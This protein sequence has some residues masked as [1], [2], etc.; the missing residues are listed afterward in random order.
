VLV[1]FDGG[2]QAK[3]FSNFVSDHT[4]AKIRSRVQFSELF[5]IMTYL[6]LLMESD[7]F[8]VFQETEDEIIVELEGFHPKG[9]D[10]VGFNPDG[11]LVEIPKKILERCTPVPSFSPWDQKE[12]ARCL[13][14][15]SRLPFEKIYLGEGKV[16]SFLDRTKSRL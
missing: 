1:I 13:A 11:G 12:Y 6:G 3:A 9:N 14:S 5:A 7:P 10:V 16:A 15:F 2:G 8:N 4:H